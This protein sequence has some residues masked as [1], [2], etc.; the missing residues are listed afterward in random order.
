MLLGITF[1]L[2]GGYY[3]YTHW[4]DK[5]ISKGIVDKG[6]VLVGKIGG[7]VKGAATE[8]V[9][10]GIKSIGDSLTQTI[11]HSIGNIVGETILSFGGYITSAGEALQEKKNNQVVIV[12]NLS[13]TIAST[14]PRIAFTVPV[15]TEFIFSLSGATFFSVLW[16]DGA[17]E[18]GAIISEESAAVAHAWNKPGVYVVHIILKNVD[19]EFEYQYNIDVTE[20][21]Q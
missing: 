2:Y 14:T 9:T 19:S 4:F 10:T 3:G 6:Q 13:T 16:G 20:K 15:N 5:S 11:S 17:S 8:A 21:N 12:G 7:N 1:A 18:N